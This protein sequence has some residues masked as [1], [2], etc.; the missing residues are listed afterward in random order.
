MHEN[1]GRSI[2]V[3]FNRVRVNSKLLKEGPLSKPPVFSDSYQG[4][5]VKRNTEKCCERS[6]KKMSTGISRKLGIKIL[7]N[8]VTRA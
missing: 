1:W 7:V 6:I 8:H 2:Y 4:H 5:I 3:H